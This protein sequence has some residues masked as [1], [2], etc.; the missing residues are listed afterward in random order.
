M[1]EAGFEFDLAYTSVLRR[2]ITTLW[3]GLEEMECHYIPQKLNWRL[4]ER[5]Y[6]ALLVWIK[7]RL[8]KSLVLNK[9]LFGVEVLMSHHLSL[10]KHFFVFT[11]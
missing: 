4:D 2:A 8:L 1:K 9:F 11:R 3:I 6:G 10:R 5:Y 7:L